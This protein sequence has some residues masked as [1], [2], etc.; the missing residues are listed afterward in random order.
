MEDKPRYVLVVE[1]NAHAGRGSELVERVQTNLLRVNEE[2]REKFTSGRLLP[3]SLH[4]VP[5]GTWRA[6][7][8][9]RTRER[10]NFEEYKHLCLVGDLNFV[11]RLDRL[12][13]NSNLSA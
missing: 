11:S 3:V 8:H 6:L 5:A 9:E 7:R 13:A 2:Y 4:E 12:A 1:P 10:G